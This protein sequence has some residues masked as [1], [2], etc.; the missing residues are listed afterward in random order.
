VGTALRA[1]AHPTLAGDAEGGCIRVCFNTTLQWAAEFSGSSDI[2]FV[3]DDRPHRKKEY[4]AVYR[5][6]SD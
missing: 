1:F 5:V 6:F 2:A 4:E 3:F